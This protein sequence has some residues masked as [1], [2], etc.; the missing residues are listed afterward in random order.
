MGV[1]E[2]QLS[3]LKS[4][5]SLKET[6]HR[7][8]SLRRKREIHAQYGTAPN[9]GSFGSSAISLSAQL[10]NGAQFLLEI[11]A[12]ICVITGPYF[13]AV[14]LLAGCHAFKIA[15]AMFAR[16]HTV[17]GS[18]NGFVVPRVYF[19]FL[20]KARG[21]NL[22]AQGKTQ[23][24]VFVAPPGAPPPDHLIT[25]FEIGAYCDRHEMYSGAKAHP[26]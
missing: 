24:L 26:C 20:V 25:D 1:Q 23:E 16:H 14:A 11:A 13:V 15:T 3:A 18:K 12:W 22:A 21:T 9:A 17:H 7:A 2:T 4:K 10:C 6:A 8:R 5:K 19:L